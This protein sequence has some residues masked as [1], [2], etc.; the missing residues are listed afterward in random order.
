MSELP[1]AYDVTERRERTADEYRELA[2]VCIERAER[3]GA[4]AHMWLLK[5]QV[6]ATLSASL[7]IKKMN[8]CEG[9]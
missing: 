5:A 9:L 7:E 2:E 4:A 8:D 3:L 1:A 6:Y